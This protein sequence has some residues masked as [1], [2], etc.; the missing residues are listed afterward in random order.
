M[1]SARLCSLSSPLH[2][3]LRCLDTWDE[4]VL[5][6]GQVVPGR[7]RGVFISNR[8]R[9]GSS[10]RR[11]VQGVGGQGEHGSSVRRRGEGVVNLMSSTMCSPPSSLASE[12][13]DG[14]IKLLSVSKLSLASRCDLFSSSFACYRS[15]RLVP[16]MVPSVSVL[17]LVVCC[18]NNTTTHVQCNARQQ[19]GKVCT[20]EEV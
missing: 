2:C 18:I 17:T 7:D 20:K 9:A 13:G 11:R 5:G 14:G 12:P 19:V 16:G 10:L 8:G 15:P 3:S 4:V 6:S 1:R